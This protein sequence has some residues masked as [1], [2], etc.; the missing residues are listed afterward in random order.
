MA[1]GFDE[2]VDFEHDLAQRIAAARAPARMEKSPSPSA[3]RR[4]ESVC[5]G[6]T[7]C[8]RSAKEKPSQKQATNTVTVHCTLGV[9]SPGPAGR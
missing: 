4:L 6:R 3:A 2:R 5:S 1:Q 9:K 7:T 8:S